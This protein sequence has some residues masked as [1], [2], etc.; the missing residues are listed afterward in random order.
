MANRSMV[1]IDFVCSASISATRCAS[2]GQSDPSVST[3]VAAKVLL[4]KI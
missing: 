2:D 3:I 4:E 1:L